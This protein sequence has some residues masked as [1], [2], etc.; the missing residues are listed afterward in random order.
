MAPPGMFWKVSNCRLSKEWTSFGAYF[1]PEEA[2]KSAL[3]YIYAL[4]IFYSA[5]PG[6]ESGDTPPLVRF[7]NPLLPSVVSATPGLNLDLCIVS[8]PSEGL[9][10][11]TR[12]LEIVCS[13]MT[14]SWTD[15]M[16]AWCLLLFLCSEISKSW[17]NF[18]AARF[19]SI[20][21]FW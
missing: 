17:M 11:L 9:P 21:L 12:Y 14:A 8:P 6:Y 19:Y 16:E 10:P 5:N 7:W 1:W 13:S 3:P 15:P 4:W 18:S 2:L 20:A